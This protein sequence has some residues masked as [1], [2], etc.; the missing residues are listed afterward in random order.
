MP[1]PR[2]WSRAALLVLAVAWGW[3]QAPAPGVP[4]A[5]PGRLEAGARAA[6]LLDQANSLESRRP[7]EALAL[8]KEGLALAVQLGDKSKEAA[9]LS[10]AGYCCSQ[11]GE[12]TQAVEYCKKALVLGME[13]G[14]RERVA[15][16]H[17]TLGISY[18][19]LGNYSLA[20]EE[21]I[22]ALRIREALG[23]EKAIAQSLNLIG[24]VYHHSGQ[25][26]KAIEY[27]EQI[28]KRPGSQND[29]RRIILA[30]HNS[31]FALYK[32]GRLDEALE[33]HLEAEALA[34]ETG[35]TILPYTHLN[36]GLTYTDL[37]RF[38][39]AREN[40]RLALAE[41]RQQDQRHGLVQVLRATAR[42][43]LLAGSYAQGIPLAK[44]G[45]D[46]ARQINARDELK[47]CHELLSELYGK[48]GR[49]EESF[50]HFRLAA[51]V[52]DTIYSA[53]ESFKIAEA[54]MKLVT[55]KKDNEIGALKREQVIA[56][57][58]L[59]KHRY[60]T[61][62]SL[63][64]TC[65][66]VT[67]VLVLGYFY[68]RMRQ[69][70]ASLERSN[71]DLARMNGEL[72]ERMKEIKTLSGLLPICGHC[73]KIRDDAGYWTQLEGYISQRTAAT[74]SHGICPHCAETHY[75]DAMDAL[76]SRQAVQAPDPEA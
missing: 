28:L 29:S 56:A 48:L 53:A 74:F 47:E 36:L 51:E 13:I 57:L 27:F 61:I 54:S 58:S 69:N 62:L 42:M 43:H 14:D 50:R 67:G 2:W 9:F 21:S 18:T 71:T 33:K 52:K 37:K 23:Q 24:V 34:R 25:Y 73:K 6:A 66:L 59:E 68:K 12:L 39:L 63:S 31:G 41:Y 20:L 4:S 15:R 1:D 72:Q 44:E 26:G 60:I 30:K 11:L 35:E 16:A 65:F 76:R 55:L 70:R 45:A 38:D 40:L 10:T 7:L 75:R 8:A 5:V 32:L 64:S 49:S 22:E 19:Y 17:N 46:L 3:A